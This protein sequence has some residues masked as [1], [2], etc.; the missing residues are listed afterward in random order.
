M[1]KGHSVLL[2]KSSAV[3]VAQ[4]AS[5]GSEAKKV[6]KEVLV[7]STFTGGLFAVYD[8]K[9]LTSDILN[10]LAHAKGKQ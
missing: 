8:K 5:Q 7:S 6:R 1:T 2:E 3:E 10:K 4:N 9:I